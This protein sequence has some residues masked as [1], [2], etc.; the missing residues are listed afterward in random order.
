MGKELF[1]SSYTNKKGEEKFS[2]GISKNYLS[3]LYSLDTK[4]FEELFDALSENVPEDF[5]TP[6][7]DKID[8]L[9]NFFKSYFAL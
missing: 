3:S 6:D 9:Q 7:E 2:I 4:S 1:L 8:G 5:Q